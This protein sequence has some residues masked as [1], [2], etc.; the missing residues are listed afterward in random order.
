MGQFEQMSNPVMVFCDDYDGNFTGT[1]TRAEIYG[2]YKDWC[3]D[4]GHKP[5]SREKFIPKFRECLGERITNEAQVRIN[6]ARTRVLVF[7]NL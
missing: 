1:L 7:Q 5:L 6:G 3:L 2:W 4:T